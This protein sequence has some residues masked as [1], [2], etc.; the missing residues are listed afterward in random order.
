M[1][2]IINFGVM[3]INNI[4]NASGVFFGENVQ[5]GWN[6]PSKSNQGQRL[7]G[8]GNV[9]INN[10]NINSDPD[11]AD[12]PNIDNNLNLPTAPVIIKAT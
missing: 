1:A 5:Q 2:V 12:S 4:T 7:Y 6:S 10:I 3:V 9:S 8:T 11:V